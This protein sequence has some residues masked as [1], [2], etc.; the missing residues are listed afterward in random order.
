[1]PQPFLRN[2]RNVFPN[3]RLKVNPSPL[4]I[5]LACTA[6]TSCCQLISPASGAY[7]GRAHS[8]A[9]VHVIAHSVLVVGYP[10]LPAFDSTGAGTVVRLARG[11]QCSCTSGRMITACALHSV[12]CGTTFYRDWGR[13]T[14]SK[15]HRVPS[16]RNRHVLAEKKSITPAD[17]SK[18]YP[19]LLGLSPPLLLSNTGTRNGVVFESHKMPRY[20]C[21]LDGVRSHLVSDRK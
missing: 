13:E 9:D 11:N 16:R 8:V 6:T 21:I 1:M 3:E 7:L 14:V 12:M 10:K 17:P 2:F 19:D 20:R 5:C 18:W 15:R 4:V